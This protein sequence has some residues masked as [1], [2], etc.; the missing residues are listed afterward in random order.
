MK[1]KK[2][3]ILQFD[4][5]GVFSAKK[6]AKAAFTGQY[7]IDCDG[8]E[9]IE[10]KWVRDGNDNGQEDGTYYISMFTKIES[11][12]QLNM[13]TLNFEAGKQLI[14][15]YLTCELSEQENDVLFC[16]KRLN[17]IEEIS[18]EIES[19][20]IFES[21]INNTIDKI[22]DAKS[23]REVFVALENTC[24]EDEEEKVLNMFIN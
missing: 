16:V 9:L 21:E 19:F 13:K 11:S 10:V 23:L 12:N 2:G 5:Q 6:G 8:G 4:P 15:E 20:Q 24:L 7:Y 14:I 1:F 17:S 18:N 3:D 22:S